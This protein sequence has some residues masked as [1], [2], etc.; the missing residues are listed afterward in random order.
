MISNQEK[1][2]EP[3]IEEDKEKNTHSGLNEEVDQ[4]HHEYIECWF[5]ATI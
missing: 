1:P 5:Q 2:L 3:E 4:G